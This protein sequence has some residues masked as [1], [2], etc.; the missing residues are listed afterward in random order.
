MSY[1]F[2]DQLKAIT[3]KDSNEEVKYALNQ[4]IR[5]LDVGMV[6]ANIQREITADINWKTITLKGRLGAMILTG[7]IKLVRDADLKDYLDV[8]EPL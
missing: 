5:A 6:E 7:E 8:K 2:A 3:T 1:N 4:L